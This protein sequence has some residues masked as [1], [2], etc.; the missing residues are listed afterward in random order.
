MKTAILTGF[1]VFGRYAVNPTEVLVR[2]LQGTVLADHHI[3]GVVFSNTIHSPDVE[4]DHGRELVEVAVAKNASAIISL[5]LASLAV[6]P[7]VETQCLNWVENDR[8]CT[9]YENHKP[10]SEVFEAKQR[11]QVPFH[12]WDLAGF[13][14]KLSM[15]GIPYEVSNDAGAYCCNALMFRTLVAM[16]IKSLDVPYIFIHV[17]CTEEAIVGIPDFDRKRKIL[18]SQELLTVVVKKLLESYYEYQ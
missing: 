16:R 15:A 14:M 17:P 18:F 13:F 2:S 6:G 8:Y 5:G 11:L 1:E 4:V 9:P 7:R 12:M 10:V 3:H